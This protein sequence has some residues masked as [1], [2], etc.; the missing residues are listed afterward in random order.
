VDQK[1]PDAGFWTGAKFGTNHIPT[2]KFPMSL[3]TRISRIQPG[4]GFWNPRSVFLVCSRPI[5]LIA[6]IYICKS[7]QFFDHV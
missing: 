2:E 1:V 3:L 6:M 5:I 4:L 7:A